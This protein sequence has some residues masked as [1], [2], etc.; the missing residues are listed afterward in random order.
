[1]P[2]EALG[3]TPTAVE[4][5]PAKPGSPQAI[6]RPEELTDKYLRYAAGIYY[7]TDLNGCTVESLAKH[8]IYGTVGLKR[9]QAWCTEDEWVKRREANREQWRKRIEAAVGSKLAQARVRQL[10]SLQ[11]VYDRA[12]AKLEQEAVRA[13]TWEGVA[14]VL[15]RIAEVMD[16]WR[17]KIAQEVWPNLSEQMAQQGSVANAMAKPKLSREEARAAALLIIQ[18]RREQLPAPDPAAEVK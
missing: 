12:L 14:G 5:L 18:K 3:H 6:A 13:N 16:D 8:P 7:A 11:R 9:L 1:M 15:I 2:I 17:A 4:V 10:E